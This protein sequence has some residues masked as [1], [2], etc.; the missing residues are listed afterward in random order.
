VTDGMNDTKLR[1]GARHQVLNLRQRLTAAEPDVAVSRGSVADEELR[2][3]FDAPWRSIELIRH[4]AG[5]TS[6]PRRLTGSDLLLFVVAGEGKAEFSS[7][8][9]ELQPG[10]SVAVLNGEEYSIVADDNSDL[11]LF[12]AEMALSD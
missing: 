5:T 7:G 8:P 9:L 10:T 2:Q 6:R 4:A 3:V 12:C 1:I 11:E